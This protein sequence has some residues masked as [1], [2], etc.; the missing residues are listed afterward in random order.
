MS[1]SREVPAEDTTVG[2]KIC[3]MEVA[4]SV[5]KLKLSSLPQARFFASKTVRVFFCTF[6][7]FFLTHHYTHNKHEVIRIVRACPGTASYDPIIAL[8][9]SDFVSLVVKSASFGL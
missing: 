2:V 9:A 5:S 1:L 8:R 6:I 4:A 7:P 3:E